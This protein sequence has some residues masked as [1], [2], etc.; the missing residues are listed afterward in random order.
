MPTCFQTHPNIL[1]CLVDQFPVVNVAI[2]YGQAKVPVE[3][4]MSRDV[5]EE[6]QF[7][8]HP[9]QVVRVSL[10]VLLMVAKFEVNFLAILTILIVIN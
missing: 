10:I 6:P 9:N 2:D 7:H 5:A 8:Y 4:A 1:N 3:M